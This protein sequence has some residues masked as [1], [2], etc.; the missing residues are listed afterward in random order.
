MKKLLSIG[1]LLTL[2]AG[3]TIAQERLVLYEEFSGENCAPCAA[4]N[5]GLWRLMMSGN[6]EQKI[7]LIKYQVP[8]PS[9]GPI[10][11][12]NTADPGARR[13]YY[14]VTSA[15]Y[16]RMDGAESMPGEGH[17]GL[18]TQESIDDA[19]AVETPFNIEI[20]S[21]SVTE[22]TVT[23]TVKVTA[24]TAMTITNLKF[25]AALN[26]TM[27]FDEPPGTNGEVEFHHVVRKMY[28]SASGQDM[29][30]TWTVG[31]E[32]TYTIT[33]TLPSYVD[34]ANEH[35]LTFWI[36]DN[37]DKSIK[38]AARTYPALDVMS[39]G[40]TSDAPPISCGLPT[41]VTPSVK[42]TNGGTTTLTSATIFYKQA[43][44]AVWAEKDWTGTLETGASTEVPLDPV[45]LTTAGVVGIIDSVGNPNDG[46][47]KFASNNKSAGTTAT[48]LQD[49]DGIFP[50]AETFETASTTVSEWTSYA[51]SDGFPFLI[52]NGSGIGYN[53][54]AFFLLYQNPS[55]EPGTRGYAVLPF[56][57]LPEGPKA[58]DFYAAYSKLNLG[59]TI[60][61]GTDKLEVVYSENCGASWV[62]VWSESGDALVSAATPAANQA[63]IP[64][65]NSQW[66]LKSVDV[67]AVPNGAQIALRATA[68]NGNYLFVDNVNLRSGAV[69][70]VE[71]IFRDG[72][73]LLYP[74]PVANQL[75]VDID[76]LKTSSGTITIVNTLGQ[77]VGT[78]STEKLNQGKNTISISTESLAAGIYFLN[79][80]T[81]EGNIQREFVKQ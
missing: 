27:Y 39:R 6:N 57:D 16:G 70:G 65:A 36:Q 45:T 76:I 55:M 79:I 63:F 80:S 46:T 53:T 58:L 11:L 2:L 35:F 19:A 81:S 69:T 8:I 14:G 26:E 41:T 34:L 38:Q 72:S 61:G 15:P 43:G 64:S 17:P 68:G 31:E 22:S 71:E 20:E 33:G 29:E 25:H 21:Y 49:E 30:D 24:L 1:T 50:I 59:G 67:S 54:S 7:L 44:A 75:T 9:A 18:L 73:F 52:Y 51:N 78:P 4:T 60:T 62:P 32:Q 47:D 28:P 13:T 5:P 40:M 74:N 48:V 10:Y 42:I 77:L 3:G 66:K 56:A 12:E 23:A 37:A